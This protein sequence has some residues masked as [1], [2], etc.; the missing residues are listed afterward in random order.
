MG[1]RY[2]PKLANALREKESPYELQIL[3]QYSSISVRGPGFSDGLQFKLDANKKRDHNSNQRIG[4]KGIDQRSLCETPNGESDGRRNANE[5][6][7][8]NLHCAFFGRNRYI[9]E[10]NSYG[11]GN[12]RF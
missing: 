3:R 2:R 8:S 9:R 4:T 6:F 7:A 1:F 11:H 10:W 12:D 5:R